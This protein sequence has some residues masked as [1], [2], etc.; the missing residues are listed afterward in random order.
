MAVQIRCGDFPRVRGLPD[1]AHHAAAVAAA[2]RVE[3][4]DRQRHGRIRFPASL[5]LAPI[6]RRRVDTSAS[7]KKRPRPA[8]LRLWRPG[9]CGNFA[10]ISFTSPATTTSAGPFAR[11]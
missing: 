10:E 6:W 8:T 4:K 7:T 9:G 11:K 3:D 5:G 2:V 1:V